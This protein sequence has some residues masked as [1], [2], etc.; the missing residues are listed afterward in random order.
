MGYGRGMCVRRDVLLFRISILR[1]GWW[2]CSCQCD[3][4][5]SDAEGHS[6]LA[7]HWHRIFPTSLVYVRRTLQK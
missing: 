4:F 7:W 1:L 2:R 6:L 3:C 5:D